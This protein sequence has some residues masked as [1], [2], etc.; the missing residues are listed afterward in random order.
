MNNMRRSVDVDMLNGMKMTV[1]INFSK[2][3]GL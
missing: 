1:N 3:D 2:D